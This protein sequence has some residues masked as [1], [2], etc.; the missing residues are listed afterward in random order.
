M[1]VA[2]QRLNVWGVVE[3]GEGEDSQLSLPVGPNTLGFFATEGLKVHPI[4]SH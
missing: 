2:K 3:W 1:G 4:R